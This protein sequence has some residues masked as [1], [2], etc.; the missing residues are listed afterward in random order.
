MIAKET[1]QAAFREYMSGAPGTGAPA[2]A[3]RYGISLRTMRRI[4]REYRYGGHH[5]QAGESPEDQGAS[6]HVPIVPVRVHIS[7]E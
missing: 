2:V 3:R 6:V 4:I 5:P 7:A 1:R